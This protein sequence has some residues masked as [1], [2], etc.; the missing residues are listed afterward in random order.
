MLT[1]AIVFLVIA[2]IA[3]WLGFGGVA[4]GAATISKVLFGIFIIIAL[5]LFAMV[6]LGIG[7]AA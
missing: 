2:I 6:L 1:W 5:V 4:K 3:G 7:V